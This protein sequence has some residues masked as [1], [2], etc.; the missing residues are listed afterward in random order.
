VPASVSVHSPSNPMVLKTEYVG[1]RKVLESEN[2]TDSSI[3]LKWLFTRA[4]GFVGTLGREPKALSRTSL[5]LVSFC[6]RQICLICFVLAFR[7]VSAAWI[8]S[9]LCRVLNGSAADPCWRCRRSIVLRG[10]TT[11]AARPLPTTGPPDWL[12]PRAEV[13]SQ[14]LTHGEQLTGLRAAYRAWGGRSGSHMG[15]AG[16]N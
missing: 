3:R 12:F 4:L 10:P 15:V 14:F 1:K 8:A 16:C 13:R 7:A 6:F 2:Q 11:A 5:C 9:R